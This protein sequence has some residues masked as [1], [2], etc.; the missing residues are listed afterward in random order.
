MK[1]IV[2]IVRVA[3]AILMLAAAPG[4]SRAQDSGSGKSLQPRM[5]ISTSEIEGGNVFEV[6]YVPAEDHTDYY[7]N[8]GHL[9]IGNEV[10]QANIDPIFNLYVKL[11]ESITEA[12]STM[13]Q[14][15]AM[16]GTVGSTMELN[17]S[18]GIAFPTE[19][20]ETVVITC[21]KPLLSK[22]LDFSL[23]RDGYLRSAACE[24]SN[25]NSLFSGLKLYKKLHPKV[26]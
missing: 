8:V 17:G 12:I 19:K 26:K 6:M 9:G 3:A 13:E 16:F 18:L 22:Y 4:L 5:V 14:L 2:S 10:V 20:T 25:L 21:R 23:V 7:L 24:K 1:R 11:G 15:K